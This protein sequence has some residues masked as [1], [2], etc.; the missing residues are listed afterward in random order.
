MRELEGATAHSDPVFVG[1]PVQLEAVLALARAARKPD[2]ATR[3]FG[4]IY[5]IS[6]KP[7]LENALG[8]GSD[9]SGLR[10]YLGYCGWGP[11]Q[12]ENEV[13]RGSWYIFDRDENLAFDAE[14]ATLWLRLIS[15]AEAQMARRG[16]T[17]PVH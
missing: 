15:K 7:A 13:E 9:S 4:E 16:F 2:G 11:H 3:L 12:L 6:G 17:L 5:V 10:V 1:G 14:P 8:E